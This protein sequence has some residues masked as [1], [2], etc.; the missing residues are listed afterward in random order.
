MDGLWMISVAVSERLQN[1]V[2]PRIG[3]IKLSDGAVLDADGQLAGTPSVMF[4]A[5]AVVLSKAVAKVLGQDDAAKAFVR[6]AFAHLKAI[7]VDGGGR[8][9]LEAS[10]VE[11]DAGV[12]NASEPTQFLE[13]AKT[14]HWGREASA[15]PQSK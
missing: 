12:V 1:V 5:I 14:R 9:L 11:P 4:D 3:G 15:R 8:I 10:S 13:L 7:A 6:D 2:A